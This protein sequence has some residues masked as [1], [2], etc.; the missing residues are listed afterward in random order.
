MI[1]QKKTKWHE[2]LQGQFRHLPRWI[3]R[4]LQDGQ[5]LVTE[6]QGNGLHKK[7]DA[8]LRRSTKPSAK[9]QTDARNAERIVV[10]DCLTRLRENTHV[11]ECMHG[12][13]WADENTIKAVREMLTGSRY[14]P[15]ECEAQDGP[16]MDEV[17]RALSDI[18]RLS[19]EDAE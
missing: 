13:L 9:Y 3:G 1:P 5:P 19:D 2:D 6:A 4:R 17:N 18:E 14:M 16:N 12:L 15:V 11:I 8:L 7:I 10:I